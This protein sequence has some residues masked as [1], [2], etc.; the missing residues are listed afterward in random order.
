MTTTGGNW[1]ASRAMAARG[2]TAPQHKN[3]A[4]G[5]D[6]EKQCETRMLRNDPASNTVTPGPLGDRPGFSIPDVY[7]NV[8]K[9]S[10]RHPGDPDFSN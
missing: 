5:T 7:D 6:F 8:N 4:S 9:T 10:Y 3:N 2:E 1:S